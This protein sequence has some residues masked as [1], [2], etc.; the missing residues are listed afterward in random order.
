MTP[1]K[2]KQES[3]CRVK[4]WIV[5]IVRC[6]DGTLYCGITNDL[7]KR[8]LAHNSGKGAVYTRGRFPVQLEAQSRAMTRSEALRLEMRIK[9]KPRK[10]KIEL[11]G[12]L[13]SSSI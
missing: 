9:K 1:E 11:L 13:G 10:K 3:Y 7:S 2:E 8:I 6:A 12:I 4:N 5:Y